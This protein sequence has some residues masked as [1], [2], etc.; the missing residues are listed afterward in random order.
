MG[1]AVNLIDD[2]SS[3]KGLFL[4]FSEKL[5]PFIS[6]LLP[7]NLFIL[8]DSEFSF[9]TQ[10][11][12]RFRGDRPRFHCQLFFELWYDFHFTFCYFHFNR[13]LFICSTLY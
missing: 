5:F 4:L 6:F 7:L 1:E 9:V 12:D 8:V 10:Q 13:R 2:S 3:R 11:C